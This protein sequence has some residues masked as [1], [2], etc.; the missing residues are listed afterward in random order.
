MGGGLVYSEYRVL[1]NR[2]KQKPLKN[3]SELLNLCNEPE[4]GDFKQKFQ[5]NPSN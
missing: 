3:C 1:L 4:F 5:P 2:K